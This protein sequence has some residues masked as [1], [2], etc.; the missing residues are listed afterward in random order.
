M[1]VNLSKSEFCQARVVFLGHIVGQGEIAPVLAKVH[2]ISNF[3]AL[4]NK[5]ELIRFLGYWSLALQEYS[6]KICHIRGRDN[7]IT[8]ALS[9]SI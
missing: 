1:T 7:V 5:H 6:L 4:S 3:P 2:T 8:D 9:R